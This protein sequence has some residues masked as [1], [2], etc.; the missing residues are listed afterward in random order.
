MATGSLTATGV[1][2]QVGVVLAT[3]VAQACI[4]TTL[5]ARTPTT[6]S[7]SGSAARLELSGPFYGPGTMLTLTAGGRTGW[8][9]MAT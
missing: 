8:S 2:A 9:A 7:I 3:G 6:A 5:L 4:N 1:D